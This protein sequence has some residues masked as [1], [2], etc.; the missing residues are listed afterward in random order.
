[1]RAPIYKKEYPM[2]ATT[3]P[4]AYLTLWAAALCSAPSAWAQTPAIYQDADL[5]LG[6][7]LIAQHNCT[8]CHA[9]KVGGNGSSI[10]RPLGRINTA[11]LLR[12]MV[13]QCNTTLGLSLFP[14]EVT[15]IAAVLN[16]EHYKFKE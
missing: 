1:L 15:A 2:T 8:Q 10:Y 5:A 3:Y 13:E 6:K 9:D 12:G 14:E 11:G 4:L 7:E 16:Q